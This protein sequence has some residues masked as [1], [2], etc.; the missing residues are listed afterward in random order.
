MKKILF[1]HP[2]MRGGGAE[3]VLVNLLNELDSNKYEITLFTLFHEGVNRANLPSQIRQK[4]L[5]SKVFRGYSVIQ[6]LFPAD[7]LFRFLIR[8]KY[9]LIVAYL[10]GVPTRIVGGCP[11]RNT[12]LVSWLHIKIDETGIEK[13][14][15]GKSE[16]IRLYHR[17]S[18][19]VCV[20]E[21]A[22]ESIISYVG[23]PSEKVVVIHNSIDVQFV[24]SESTKASMQLPYPSDRINLV[25]VGRLM[26]Q[27]GYDRLLRIV[28]RLKNDDIK[29]HLYVLGDG[30]L[31]SE[32]QSYIQANNLQHFVTLLGFHTNPYPLVKAADLFVCSSY[33]EGYSTAV[34][35]A[36]LL[37][38]PVVT[39]MCSGMDEILGNGSFGI[40]TKNDEDSLYQGLRGV[41][42]SSDQLS[43]YKRMAEER[44]VFFS[45]NRN[46][47]LVE[48][49][50][51][52][53]L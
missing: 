22:R 9:D 8:E 49:L 20:S 47:V 1:V 13:V 30:D 2:D 17:F 27:K 23:L 34:T 33:N 16:M 46:V 24:I 32:F 4:W 36:I 19:V 37:K 44:S 40:I 15:R 11:N 41:L 45:R 43:Y 50:I 5:F 42:S 52:E 39:T 29:F 26:P 38:V 28:N 25:T 18:K 6:K 21:A 53:L 35:E 51:D 7:W 3:K 31:K 14:F 10:E 12:R 48:E